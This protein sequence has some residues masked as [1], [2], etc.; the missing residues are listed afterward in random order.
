MTPLSFATAGCYFCSDFQSAR[1]GLLAAAERCSSVF[2][3]REWSLPGQAQ[4]LITDAIWLGDER[5]TRALVLISGTHGIEGYAGSAVQTFLLDSLASGQLVLPRDLG[6]LIV[7]ALNPWGMH[8]ARRCDQEGVDLNR[9]FIDFTQVPTVDTHYAKILEQLSLESPVLARRALRKLADHW[10]QRRF[11]EL[12]SGGQYQASWAPFYGGH[13][14]SFAS[15]LIDELIAH[16]SLAKRELIV[17]DLHTGLGPWAFGELISDHPPSS[18]ANS[19]ARALFGDA[20]AVTAEEAS[21]S[22]PKH[23]LLDYRWHQLMQERGCFLTLEFGTYR[24]D[25]LFD[26]LLAEHLFWRDWSLRCEPTLSD[27]AYARQRQAML[28]HFC[29]GDSLWQQSVLFKAWQVV[30]RVCEAGQ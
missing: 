28:G 11:D 27:P 4:A 9:N 1:A 13:E 20:I 6:L 21:S 16:W 12:F 3:H 2:A 22:V 8:W 29:P 15:R 5:A 7:H 24:T 17:V 30:Q 18:A 25:S 10:G 26:V 23:G 14:A 19:Y